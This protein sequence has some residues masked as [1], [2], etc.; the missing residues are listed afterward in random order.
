M[1]IESSYIGGCPVCCGMLEIIIG[2]NDQ[3]CSIMCDECSAEWDSPENAL[4]RIGGSRSSSNGVKVR[5]ATFDE[6]K[7]A[8]WG[9]YVI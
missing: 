5:T 7:K 1:C 9:K 6:I 3:K 2:V 8:N 4:N